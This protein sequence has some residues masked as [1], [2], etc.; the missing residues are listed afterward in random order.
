LES[1]VEW[2]ARKTVADFF[3]LRE[4]CLQL[5]PGLASEFPLRKSRTEGPGTLTREKMERLEAFLRKMG[6]LMDLSPS[7]HTYQLAK[8]LQDFVGATER[9]DIL[10]DM[11][12][13]NADVEQVRTD[14]HRVQRSEKEG[15][16]LAVSGRVA[17]LVDVA[18]DPGVRVRRA[19]SER[20]AAVASVGLYPRHVEL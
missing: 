11:Q 8:V 4:V 13:R 7:S 3:A 10:V 19:A 6:V 2:K 12:H 5:A 16:T 1:G 18:G 15:L 14:W 20:V 9:I 17:R